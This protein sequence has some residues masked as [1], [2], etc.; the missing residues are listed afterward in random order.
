MTQKIDLPDG[1]FMKLVKEVRE[2]RKKMHPELR[3]FYDELAQAIL[4]FSRR[5]ANGS[6][7]DQG[8]HTP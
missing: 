7:A 4:P 6:S 3:R 2:E 5:Q 1:W 8:D